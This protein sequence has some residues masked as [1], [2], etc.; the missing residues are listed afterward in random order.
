M[1]PQCNACH[2]IYRSIPSIEY[3]YCMLAAIAAS[4]STIGYKAPCKDYLAEL[5]S[6]QI[7]NAVDV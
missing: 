1:S 2:V 7:P 3:N 6:E 4:S 5:I